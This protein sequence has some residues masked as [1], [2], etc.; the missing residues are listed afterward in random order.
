MRKNSVKFGHAVS[1]ICQRTNRQT[2]RQ[3]DEIIAKLRFHPWKRK[4]SP[5]AH[6]DGRTT[7]K[8]NSYGSI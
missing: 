4:A 2:D 3:T 6:T 8:H 5:D 1:E 7:R